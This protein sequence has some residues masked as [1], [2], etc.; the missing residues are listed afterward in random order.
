[1]I[2][3]ELTNLI[4]WNV[5]YLPTVEQSPQ[6]PLLLGLVGLVIGA[7]VKLGA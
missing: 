3:L 7:G 6:W 2:F 5:I 1:M 4:R